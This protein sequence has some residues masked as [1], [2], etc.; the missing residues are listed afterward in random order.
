M[1]TRRRK[2][3]ISLSHNLGAHRTSSLL[4]RMVHRG[5]DAGSVHGSDHV[6]QRIVLRLRLG[7]ISRA[8]RQPRFG[9]FRL[10]AVAGAGFRETLQNRLNGHQINTPDTDN[11]WQSPKSTPTELSNTHLGETRRR[12]REFVTVNA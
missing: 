2:A 4:D 1:A 8:S 3:T 10:K 7:A 5:T 9:I 12:N 11:D 6:I